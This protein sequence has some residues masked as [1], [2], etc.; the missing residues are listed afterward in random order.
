MK[1]TL[2]KVE[3]KA[4]RRPMFWRGPSARF[5]MGRNRK[6]V[7]QDFLQ[8]AVQCGGPFHEGLESCILSLVSRFEFSSERVRPEP[9]HWINNLAGFRLSA[10]LSRFDNNIDAKIGGHQMLG[11]QNT[12]TGEIRI[13]N[14]RNPN[15]TRHRTLQPN[16][17]PHILSDI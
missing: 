12:Q 17:G 1:A 14:P 5:V 2:R 9:N 3:A 10:C 4:S 7:P 16:R 11:D 13:G 8:D 6:W 15:P